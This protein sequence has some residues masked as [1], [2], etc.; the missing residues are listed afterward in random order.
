MNDNARKNAWYSLGLLALI[1]LVYAYRQ[2]TQPPM[3][4][5]LTGTTMG[6]ISYHVKYFDPDKR[7]FGPQVDSLLKAFNA[8]L[9][10][11]IP[12]SEISRFNRGD[13]LRFESPFFLPVL[14][15]SREIHAQTGGAFDPTVMPLVNAWGFGPQKRAELPLSQIDSLLGL[16]GFEKIAFDHQAVWKRQPYVALDFS[17]IAKGYAIDVVAEFLEKQGIHDYMV[18]IGGEARCKGGN[19]FREAWVIGV[20]NPKYAE[21]GGAPGV[22]YV[23]LP[24]R[25]VATSGNYRNYYEKDGK[26]YAHTISPK[27]G[28][29]VSHQLLSASVFAPDCMTADAYATA[30]MVLGL[31]SAKQVLARVPAL[32]ALLVYEDG[33]Q[34]RTFATPDVEAI[35]LREDDQ[36]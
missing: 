20:D 17:A 35:L 26:R 5:V 21:N 2:W 18:L 12:E 34:M 27:T 13:T 33:R 19:G 28:H 30:F 1:G 14:Q 10:T 6:K 7:D 31:D 8:S 24:N 23:A 22:A 25:S 11:Y 16:V 36:R 3:P 32:G 9:S 29:P 15:A 4:L